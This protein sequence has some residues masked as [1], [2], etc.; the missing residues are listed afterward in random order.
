ME[1]PVKLTITLPASTAHTVRE[2]VR[3]GEY[4]SCSE[5]VREALDA[6]QDREIDRLLVGIDLKA[7]VEEA[8]ND[9]R[10]RRTPKQVRARIER[11]HRRATKAG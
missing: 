11:L 2:A 10:P 3:T 6:L 1:S 9:P 4:S 8:I 7:A 5:M